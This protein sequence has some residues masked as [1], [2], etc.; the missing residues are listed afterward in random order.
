MRA[1][2]RVS[3]RFCVTLALAVVLLLACG[4]V[5]IAELSRHSDPKDLRAYLVKLEE[6]IQKNPERAEAYAD[7]AEIQS[8]L[9]DYN[10]AL[11]SINKAITLKP[12]EASFYYFRGSHVLKHLHKNRD[13]CN[14]YDRAIDLGMSNAEVYL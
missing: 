13:E 7:K 11:E 3:E 1:L 2:I 12:Y 9:H 14:D 8:W 10:G 6:H 5:A 4:N